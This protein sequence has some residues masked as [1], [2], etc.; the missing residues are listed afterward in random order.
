MRTEVVDLRRMQV[1]GDAILDGQRVKAVDPG[2]PSQLIVVPPIQVE[3]VLLGI[4]EFTRLPAAIGKGP[5]TH[6]GN[7]TPAMPLNLLSD[8]RIEHRAPALARI[9]HALKHLTVNQE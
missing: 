8:E 3:P 6:C 7:G 4:G 2:E 1:W 5:D 9:G